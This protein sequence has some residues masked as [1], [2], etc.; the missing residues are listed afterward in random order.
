MDLMNTES[1]SIVHH[2]LNGTNYKLW[3]FQIDAVIKSRGLADAVNGNVP[4]DTA[5]EENKRQYDRD[6]GRAMAILISS[7]DTEQANHVLTC[8]TA[9]EIIDK[10]SALYEK[11]IEVRIMCLYEEYFSLKMNENESV[12]AFVS[13][14]SR[15][16]LEIE[17]QGEKLSDNIKMVRIISGLTQKETSRQFG[18]TSE[19]VDLSKACFLVCN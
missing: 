19:K 13:K 10:L 8:K 4:P 14:V 17:D 5:S 11:R 2:K 16:A 1:G 18:T 3:K 6:D 15:M 12:A 9:K 7:M